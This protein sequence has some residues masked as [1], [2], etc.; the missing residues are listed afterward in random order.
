MI[1]PNLD[2]MYLA[3]T[4]VAPLAEYIPRASNDKP[5][6]AVSTLFQSVSMAWAPEP[7]TVPAVLN[8]QIYNVIRFLLHNLEI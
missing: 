3:V 6:A 8:K 4:P 2:S 7:I 1:L 5:P